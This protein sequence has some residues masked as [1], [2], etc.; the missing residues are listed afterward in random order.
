MLIND[1]D[2]NISDFSKTTNARFSW[3][4]CSSNRKQ[5][6]HAIGK[7]LL[8]R[9]RER[10]RGKRR[11]FDQWCRVDVKERSTERYQ[12][13]SEGSQKIMFWEV[14][15]NST[16]MD[17][18]SENIFNEEVD[19]LLLVKIQ[20]REKL[21]LNECNMEIQ[22]LERRNSEHAFVKSQRELESQRQQFIGSQSDQARREREHICVADWGWRTIFIKNA[23]QEVFKKLKNFKRRCYQEENTE[24]QRRLEEFPMQHDQESRTVSL[25]FDDPDLLSSY[26]SSSVP[27]QTLTTSSSR[28]PSREVEMPRNAR[29][30]MSIPG[31]VFDRQHARR[32]PDELHN[33]SR[34][35]ATPSRI[36]DD[37]EDSEKKKELRI[38][39]AEN[40]CN[41]YLYLSFQQEQGEKV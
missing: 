41:Q 3:W 26:D 6:K 16:L 2:H 8:D 36:A 33:C 5:R 22:N 39:G 40:H 13:E 1:P 18:I 14:S 15:E 32:D 37:V 25:F 34:K 19:K 24:K 7:P 27:H 21:Y 10:E 35:L 12:C 11:F 38:V 17:E 29:E 23:M 20:V 28:K 9:E 30:D 31:N 4:F